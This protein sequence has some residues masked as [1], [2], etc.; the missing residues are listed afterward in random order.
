MVRAAPSVAPSA[1]SHPTSEESTG[2]G[3]RAALCQEPQALADGHTAVRHVA[4][5]EDALPGHAGLRTLRLFS[6]P[7]QV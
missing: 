3:A 1:T 7:G 5:R 2:R 4:R 6:I